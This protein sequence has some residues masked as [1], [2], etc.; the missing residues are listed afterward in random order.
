MFQTQS[1]A[2]IEIMLWIAIF[3]EAV[4]G[5]YTE[6][7]VFLVIQ[8]INYGISL[9]E[10]IVS[11]NTVAALK[12]PSTTLL[13]AVKRDGLWQDIESSLIVPGDLVKLAAGSM[14]PADCR[15][16]EVEL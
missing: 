7:A 9:S 13:A 15:L 2:P 14:I 4:L 16:N 1:T 10:A 11:N 5:N 3:V 12:A 6:T 8:F